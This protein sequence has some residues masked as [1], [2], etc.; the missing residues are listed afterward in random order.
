MS[1]RYGQ[2]RT[3]MTYNG[4]QI[5][6]KAIKN[7]AFCVHVLHDAYSKRHF[8]FGNSVK[9]FVFTIET[10]FVLCE[11]RTDLRASVDVHADPSGRA[12]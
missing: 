3:N 8:I 1:A 4:S 10:G 9:Q 6:L 12:V 5:L 11:L 2:L 7:S